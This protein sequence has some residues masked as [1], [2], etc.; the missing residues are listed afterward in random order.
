M[1]YGK[2]LPDAGAML[3]SLG[4]YCQDRASRIRIIIVQKLILASTISSLKR[5]PK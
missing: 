2:F 3:F 1:G 4:N 5:L